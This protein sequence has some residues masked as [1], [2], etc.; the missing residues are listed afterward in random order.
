MEL[1]DL[2][3]ASSVVLLIGATFSEGSLRK[4]LILVSFLMLSITSLVIHE[5]AFVN[6]G[7]TAAVLGVLCVCSLKPWHEPWD[8]RDWLLVFVLFVVLGISYC[9]DSPQ[10][11]VKRR[12]P[13]K[14]WKQKTGTMYANYANLNRS[15]G[16]L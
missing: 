13:K 6:I 3:V 12:Q 16:V 14:Q 1:S 15:R 10:D 8:K 4:F 7:I 5:F 2:W 9:F 11:E